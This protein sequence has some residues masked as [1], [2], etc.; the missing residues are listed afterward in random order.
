MICGF[1]KKEYLSKRKCS[2]FCSKKCNAL[3]QSEKLRRFPQL[4][5]GDWLFDQYWIKKNSMKQIA[6]SLGIHSESRVYTAMDKLG[7]SRRTIQESVMGKKQ[8]VKHRMNLSDVA[9]GRWRGENNP[10]WKGGMKRESLVPRFNYDYETWRRQIKRKFNFTCIMCD[11]KLN[12]VCECCGQKSLSYSH[13]IK[14]VNEFPELATDVNNGFLL[15]YQCH[16]KIH[17]LSPDKLGE[18]VKLL[19]NKTIPC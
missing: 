18:T 15:C 10:N 11:K 1:C 7:I 3:F 6:N 13:H 14:Q 4:L 19:K 5:D 2:M 8:S 9:K 17:K 16:Q 12:Q